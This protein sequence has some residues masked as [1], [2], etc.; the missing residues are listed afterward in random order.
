MFFVL[1][2][3]DRSKTQN[4]LKDF[5]FVNGNLF[6]GKIF[7]PVFTKSTRQMIVNGAS[8]DW[9]MINPDILGSMLQAV[10]SPEE[11]EEDEMHYTSVP[12]IMKVIGP[13]FIDDLEMDEILEIIS[14]I[15][16]ITINNIMLDASPIK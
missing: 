14:K 5:P 7:L 4:Y 8:L 15:S 9:H 3:D 1:N 13:L 10:V 12:N 16:A 2:T 6:H 11:R